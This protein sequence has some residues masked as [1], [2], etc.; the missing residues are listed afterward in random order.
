MA[1]TYVKSLLARTSYGPVHESLLG[2]PGDFSIWVK[3]WLCS[4]PLSLSQLDDHIKSS[5]HNSLLVD[6]INGIKWAKATAFANSV[7][8]CWNEGFPMGWRQLLVQKSGPRLCERHAFLQL[9][10][11]YENKGVDQRQ[12]FNMT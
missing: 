6:G 11:R 8:D 4:V 3:C 7:P 1:S 5:V 2:I 10:C 9:V 12:P